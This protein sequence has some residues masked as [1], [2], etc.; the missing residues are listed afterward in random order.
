MS[1]VDVDFGVEGASTFWYFNV[2]KLQIL[3]F[4]EQTHQNWVEVNSDKAFTCKFSLLFYKQELVELFFSVVFNANN[5]L[6]NF[7]LLKLIEVLIE[8]VVQLLY[9]FELFALLKSRAKGQ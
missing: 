6:G 3:N 2:E 1:S 5:P 8:G 9:I 4:S 7:S